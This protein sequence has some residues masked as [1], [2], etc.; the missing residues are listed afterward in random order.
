MRGCSLYP[1]VLVPFLNGSF[2]RGS[3]IRARG[4]FGRELWAGV[5][6]RCGGDLGWKIEVFT[7]F[8]RSRFRNSGARGCVLLLTALT[9]LFLLV[10][11]F[12]HIT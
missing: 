2:L 10:D 6:V 7:L 9:T 4:W 11:L 1:R 12:Y 5:G 3:E 8:A